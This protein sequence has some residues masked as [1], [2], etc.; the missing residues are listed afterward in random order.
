[1]ADALSRRD[2]TEPS[3]LEILEINFPIY[4]K[5]RDEI[6]ESCNHG[7]LVNAILNGRQASSWNFTDDLILYNKRIHIPLSSP[8]LQDILHAIHDATHEGSKKT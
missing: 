5:L 4:E 8:L 1:V 3:L 2:P 7:K 6:A